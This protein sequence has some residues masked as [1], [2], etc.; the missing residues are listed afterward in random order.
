LFYIVSQ[1]SAC[2]L[3][4]PDLQEQCVNPAKRSLNIRRGHA[5]ADDAQQVNDVL[6]AFFFCMSA[7]VCLVAAVVLM[8]L[9]VAATKVTKERPRFL[10]VVVWLA[11]L[12][13]VSE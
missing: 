2:D 8:L 11:S 10:L 13:A 1:T 4:I 12:L 5:D 9:G 3:R 6:F 7:F